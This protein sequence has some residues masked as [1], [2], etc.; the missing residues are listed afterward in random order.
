MIDL[1]KLSR[2]TDEIFP[3]LV[4]TLAELVK[5][6][7]ISADSAK[8]AEVLALATR[9]AELFADLGLETEVLTAPT[10]EGIPG[11]PAMIARRV[12][13][14]QAPT[15]LLYAHHDVQPTGDLALWDTEPFIATRVGDRLFGRGTS[16]DG[17]GI[18][19]HLGA[20]ELLGD[21]LGV[22]VTVYIEGEEEIGSPSFRNFLAKYR[23]KL[24]AD[25]IV[26]ADSDNWKV[27]IP[28][29]TTS[30]RGL[31]DIFVTVRVLKHAVH[32]GMFGG[33]VLDA[34][35]SAARLIA[36]LHDENGDVAVPGLGG[37]NRADVDYP[38]ADLRADIGILDSYRLAG[39][40]DIAARMW[41]KPA[42]AVVGMD[43][44]SIAETANVIAP[45]CRFLLS[46]RTV[47]GESGEAAFVAV[48]KHL[49][50]NAPF[51]AELEI[52]AGE[53]GPSYQA[54]LS[55]VASKNAHWALTNAWDC[56]SVNIGVG[57]SIPF[58]SDFAEIF[59]D[60]QVVV[61]GVEDPQ[62]N[63]HSAN[64]SQHLGDLRNAVLAEALFLAKTAQD[65]AA[66]AAEAPKAE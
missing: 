19:V 46:L 58:I 8:E 49:E 23:D 21:D 47:P 2:R 48:K 62:T 37:A 30:L 65:H 14:P 51:G 18:I 54:D 61:T 22:N 36:T 53:I 52:T 34:V 35:T 41:N 42:I 9:V 7:S 45:E 28:A 27:G 10:P 38:E 39:T 3:K 40:G 56:P 13:D 11:K 24:E 26:V 32:S 63:A 25:V 20:L 57:G 31:V 33:P 50:A 12:V 59:P 16:D 17:A 44:T 15:V 1:A 43:A 55:S 29:V 60:A 5:Y 6:Q 4:D 66:A 64:E